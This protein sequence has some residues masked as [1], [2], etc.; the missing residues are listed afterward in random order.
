MCA[1]QSCAF[2]SLALDGAET[3]PC[4]GIIVKNGIYLCRGYTNSAELVAPLLTQRTTH[5][6]DEYYR[7]GGQN[8]RSVC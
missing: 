8:K 4:M 2:A 3:V 5:K 1:V 7:S 6:F